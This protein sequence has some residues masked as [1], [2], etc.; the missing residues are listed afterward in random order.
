MF[1]DLIKNLYKIYKK[2]LN[3]LLF[4]SS[5]MND[6]YPTKNKDKEIK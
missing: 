6:L 5:N 4:S 1:M 2:I 3:F